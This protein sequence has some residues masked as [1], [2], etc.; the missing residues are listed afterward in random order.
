MEWKICEGIS[1]GHL[2]LEI[3]LDSFPI[4]A[5]AMRPSPEL[6]HAVFDMN[7]VVPSGPEGAKQRKVLLSS[8]LQR[9]YIGSNSTTQPKVRWSVR[10][11]S[12]GATLTCGPGFG[13]RAK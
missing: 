4:Q 2:K 11:G 8:L 13:I 9:V 7:N 1:N 5:P 6:R 10:T 3:L 12:N